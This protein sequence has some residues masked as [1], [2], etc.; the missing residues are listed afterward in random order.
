MGQSN[1]RLR[2]AHRAV[3]NYVPREGYLYVRSRAISSRCNDNYDFFSAEEIKGNGSTTGYKTFIGKPVFVNH[4]NEDHRRMR[5]VIIDSVLHEDRNPDGSPDT[6]SEV[7]M[8]VDAVRFPKLA[9]AILAGHIDRTSMGVDVERSIC[10]VCANVAQTPSDYCRHIP[11]MKGK[12]YQTVDYKTGAKHT[13]LVYEKCAGLK[14]FENSLLVEDPADPTA[15]TLGSPVLG[16]GL[17]PLSK[18]AVHQADALVMRKVKAPDMSDE[19]LRDTDEELK[20]RA[21]MLGRPGQV[22]KIHK[23]VQDELRVRHL[24]TGAVDPRIFDVPGDA[25]PGLP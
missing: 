2:T 7:L 5:G 25:V 24:T 9:Q 12:R 14:F 3:F 18:V 11:A 8:E 21:R 19:D 22:S 13:N 1:V 10:S 17:E 20:R 15:F 16:P 23:T 6:W 4:H